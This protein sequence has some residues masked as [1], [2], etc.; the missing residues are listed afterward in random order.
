MEWSISKSRTWDYF[1]CDIGFARN[2]YFLFTFICIY[3]F[4][5]PLEVTVVDI[6]GIH[7]WW[8]DKVFYVQHEG[9]YEE[10]Q[11]S[12]AWFFACRLQWKQ[13]KDAWSQEW[14]IGAEIHADSITFYGLFSY[15]ILLCYCCGLCI[16]EGIVFFLRRV[17]VVVKITCNCLCMCL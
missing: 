16:V 17:E 5:F 2:F 6:N 9:D 1:C 3:L 4:F 14:R 12:N 15:T 7:I 13:W 10:K 11:K 8:S